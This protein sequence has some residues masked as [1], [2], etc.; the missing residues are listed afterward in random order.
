MT[1][2]K[3]VYLD[4]QS[5]C[6]LKV[7]D[8]V[9]VLRKIDNNEEAWNDHWRFYGGDVVG[10]IGAILHIDKDGIGIKFDASHG[11]CYFPYFVLEKVE[12]PQHEFKPFD[13]VLVRQEEKDI[14]LC[15]FFSF[16][17]KDA[18]GGNVYICI[19]GTYRYCI[20]Y[21]DNE[22]LIGTTDTPEK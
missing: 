14:W 7:G 11:T 3:K 4:A 2:V 10:M 1:T 21:E 13:K 15:E 20:P 19:G 16:F 17:D 5:A 9:K 12:K 18:P 22:H 6:D 8:Y